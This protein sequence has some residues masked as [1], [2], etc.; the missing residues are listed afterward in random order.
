ME[1]FTAKTFEIPKLS[2]ISE[3]TIE[4]HLK[5]YKGYVNNTNTIF[6]KLAELKS[7]PEKNTFIL[8]ELQRRLGFEF[9]GM[10]NHEYYFSSLSGGSKEIN[11]DGELYKKIVEDFGSFENFLGHF[12]F[13][14]MTRGIGWSMLY[15]DKASNKLIISWLD[16][17]HIGHLAGAS[18]VLCL[19]MWEHSYYLDYTP[20]EKK[21]YIE[22]FFANLNWGVI[23]DNYQKLIK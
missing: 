22:S 18:L 4:E 5:L 11:K 17:Q 20:A 7:D 10:R 14:A 19:D 16:E 13:V 15:Y 12:K 2:G 6:N 23:E 21:N 3:K 8:G 1:T 9:G